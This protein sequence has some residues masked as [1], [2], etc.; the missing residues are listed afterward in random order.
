MQQ[1]YH[2]TR[3]Y[4]GVHISCAALLLIH[5]GL[6]VQAKSFHQVKIILLIILFFKFI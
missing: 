1:Q 2:Y 3:V 5:T 4:E 6:L